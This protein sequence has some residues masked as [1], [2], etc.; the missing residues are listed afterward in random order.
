MTV[1]LLAV[2]CPLPMTLPAMVL[3]LKAL[4]CANF[5]AAMV[6]V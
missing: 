3:G 2:W 5:I 6:D 1:L 4:A